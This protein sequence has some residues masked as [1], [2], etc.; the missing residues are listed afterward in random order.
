LKYDPKQNVVRMTEIPTN[1]RRPLKYDPKQNVVRMTKTPI[2]V[3]TPLKYDPKIL[4]RVILQR[5]A[6]IYR[7]F[8]ILTTFCLGSYFKGRLTLLGISVILTTFC[9][10]SY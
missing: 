4:F 6:D 1:V 9:L 5:F 3:S 8:V 10:G 2:N 7:Y